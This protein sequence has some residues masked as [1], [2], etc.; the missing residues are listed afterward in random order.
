MS[1]AG[2]TARISGSP[3]C[4]SN[5]PHV[6]SRS[7]T[8]TSKLPS[9]S[10][11]VI[12]W[13]FGIRTRCFATSAPEVMDGLLVQLVDRDRSAD[14]VVLGNVLKARTCVEDIGGRQRSHERTGHQ[15]E[16][17]DST[18]RM[19]RVSVKC[20]DVRQNRIEVQPSAYLVARHARSVT[21]AK[22]C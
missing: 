2:A 5:H 19:I 12:A 6:S 11:G 3:N 13:Y 8:E 20:L 21:P 14:P 4:V 16:V 18:R 15:R 17:C 7:R 10:T 1:R 9:N 22:R